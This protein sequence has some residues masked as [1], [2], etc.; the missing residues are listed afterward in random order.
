MAAPTIR[1]R[2]RV[3]QHQMVDG[4]FTPQLVRT[5]LILLTG[6][7]GLVQSEH[8]DADFAYHLVLDALTTEMKAVARAKIR[9]F[10]TPEYSRA[11]EA[12]DTEELVLQMVMSCK[13]FLD[14]LDNE[15]RMAG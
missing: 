3:I 9:S 1:E 8:R 12:G 14:S 2:I 7:F 13:K 10:T 11:R 6:L 4:A 15:M 5:N